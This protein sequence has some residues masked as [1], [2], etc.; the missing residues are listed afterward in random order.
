VSLLDINLS[1]PAFDQFVTAFARVVRFNLLLGSVQDFFILV[2]ILALLC[3][4]CDLFASPYEPEES[5]NAGFLFVFFEDGSVTEILA[6][7]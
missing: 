7:S 5:A 3:D 1:L 6:S 2:I 4:R